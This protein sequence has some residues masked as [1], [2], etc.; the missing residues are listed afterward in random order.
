M[1]GL[2]GAIIASSCC[3]VPLVLVMLGIGGAWIGNLTALEPYKPYFIA[4]TAVLLGLGYW[5][6]YFKPKK[7][8]EAGSYCANPASG[9]ITK[10]ALWLATVIVLLAATVNYWAPLF[11]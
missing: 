9:R 2:L 1:T 6:V 3:I 10:A 5:H 8:C 11:Y 7:V 4:G